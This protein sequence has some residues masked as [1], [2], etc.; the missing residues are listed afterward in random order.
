MA[1]VDFHKIYK[2]YCEGYIKFYDGLG[3]SGININ[4]KN[5]QENEKIKQEN[6]SLIEQNSLFKARIQ[7]L[8]T[9]VKD[10]T[11][12]NELLQKIHNLHNENNT[13]K[14]IQVNTD[15]KYSEL[16]TRNF[17]LMNDNKKLYGTNAI[18][19]QHIDDLINDK[20]LLFKLLDTKNCTD[21]EKIE[22]FDSMK[23]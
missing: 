21:D 5:K 18:Q 2:L 22:I 11:D 10:I 20:A 23:G 19:I 6:Q 12:D 7:Q 4:E 1:E 13:I 14:Q 8:K 3:G 9:R 16:T 15:R 17:E